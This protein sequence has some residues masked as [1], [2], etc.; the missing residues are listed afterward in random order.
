LPLRS[1]AS[2]RDV[3][4]GRASPVRRE[5]LLEATFARI[6]AEM[7]AAAEARLDPARLTRDNAAKNERHKALRDAGIPL[8]QEAM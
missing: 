4:V 6:E 1:F 8:D 3:Q 7:R 5:S 2:Y